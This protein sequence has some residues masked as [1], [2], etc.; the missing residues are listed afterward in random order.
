ML[1]LTRR[2]DESLVIDDRII[3]TVLGVEGEKVKIGITAPREVTVLRQE[4]WQAIKE[5]N[6]LAKD[7]STRPEPTTFEELR[8]MIASMSE[9]LESSGSAA[10]GEQKN[11]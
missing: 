4:L 8:K 2:I 7:L 9:D 5:Q 6:Q 10:G 1:V 11:K 3:I